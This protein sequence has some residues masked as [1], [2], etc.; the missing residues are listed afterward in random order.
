[1]RS[2]DHAAEERSNGFAPRMNTFAN[3]ASPVDP[4]I[5]VYY[6][7]AS[8]MPRTM[9]VGRIIAQMQ[10]HFTDQAAVRMRS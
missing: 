9:R 10:L 4:P 1:M 5:N 7:L 6:M 2:R 8:C 3:R